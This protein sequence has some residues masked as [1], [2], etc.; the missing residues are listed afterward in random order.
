MQACLNKAKWTDEGTASPETHCGG[1]HGAVAQEL[2]GRCLVGLGT[3][4]GY[5]L[6]FFYHVA[7][8]SCVI[9]LSG[10]F[11]DFVPPDLLFAQLYQGSEVGGSAVHREQSP[12]VRHWS[13]AFPGLP[14]LACHNFLS[15]HRLVLLLYACGYLIKARQ[16]CKLQAREAECFILL[17]IDYWHPWYHK[18]VTYCKSFF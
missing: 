10:V 13:G 2:A 8:L 7:N 4:K 15:F 16:L 12:S 5:C 1:R 3:D 9:P 11:G 6:N 17:C 18:K 14:L